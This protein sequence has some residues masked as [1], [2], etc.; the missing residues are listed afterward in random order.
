MGGPILCQLCMGG[1]WERNKDLD[2]NYI[3]YSRMNSFLHCWYS[4]L[5]RYLR[6]YYLE[7]ISA[8]AFI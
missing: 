7:H 1:N 6:D 5:V 8:E 4:T 3:I 2:D